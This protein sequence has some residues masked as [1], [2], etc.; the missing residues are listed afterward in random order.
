LQ[1]RQVC[2][3]GRFARTADCKNGRLQKS[4]RFPES[5]RPANVGLWNLL[6]WL[7]GSGRILLPAKVRKQLKVQAGSV[8]IGR[9][10][11]QK[12]ILNTG[13]EALRRAQEYFSKFRPK[14][15][16]LLSDE[17]IED[18]RKEARRELED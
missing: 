3:N 7:D 12:L 16:K 4:G 5:A 13:D 11:K 2:K 1:E 6:R 10:D 17:L 8:L 18:R 15:G 9:L 14:N